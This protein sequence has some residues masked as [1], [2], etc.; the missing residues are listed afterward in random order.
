VSKF[1]PPS[2]FDGYEL[3]RLLGKGGMGAVYLAHDTLLDRPVA[4]K[5][6]SGSSQNSQARERFMVE[7]RAIARLQHT[8]VVS[9]YRVG[10]VAETPYLV[11]EFIRGTPLDRLE[12]P[13][14]SEDALSIALDVASGLA[15]AHRR[16]VVH[17]DI[18]PANAI[19][20]HD[21][22]VK[23]LDFGIAK[24]LPTMQMQSASYAAPALP[25]L[26]ADT[27]SAQSPV[28]PVL[29]PED[30]TA[31][32][33]PDGDPSRIIVDVNECDPYNRTCK[34]K[35]G[36][37]EASAPRAD[38]STM[39]EEEWG[40][41]DELDALTDPGVALGTPRYMA[42]EIWARQ[43]AS[44][45]SDVYSFGALLYSLCAGRPPHPER[46][47]IKLRQNVLT[48]D[49]EPLHQVA[50]QIDPQLCAII[51]RCL[52]RL[53]AERYASGSEL[54]SALVTLLPE[55][56]D[57]KVPAGNPYRGLAAF[58]AQHQNLYFGRD[59]EIR[60]VLER[61][62]REAFVLVAGDSGVGKSSLC[63]AGVLP[64]VDRW[65][66][67]GQK[68]PR[69]WR[70]VSVV[71]GRH[72]VVSLAT[73]LAPYLK[74]DV[75]QLTREIANDQ[76]GVAR[77][78]RAWGG[79][80]RGLV[81]F[82]DQL[83][84]LMTLSVPDEAAATADLLGWLSIAA[85]GLRVLATVRGDFL[86]RAATLPRIGVE[87]PQ[88]LY[89]LRPL[90]AERIRDAITG[91]ADVTKTRFEQAELI[92][93]L[94]SS[95]RQAEAGLP[96]LQFALAEL[97]EARDRER[98]MISRESLDAI[99][100]VIGALNKHADR[101]IRE[102]LPTQ[103]E[104]AREV[105]LALVTSAG[106]RARKSDRELESELAAAGAVRSGR[107]PFGSLVKS[108]IAALVRGRL[109]VAREASDGASYEI[110]HEALIAGWTTL[111]DWLAKDADAKRS[112]E[113]LLLAVDEWR[114]L[115]RASD[116]LWSS[117][118]LQTLIGLDMS[119]LSGDERAFIMTSRRAL[120]RARV[121]RFS[122]IAILVVT[123][124]AAYAGFRLQTK[125]EIS[126]R[127]ASAL[128]AAKQLRR[129]AQRMLAVAK[130]ER[131]TAFA[132]F[133]AGRLKKGEA[134]W[135]RVRRAEDRARGHLRIA[136]T[137]AESAVMLDP[138]R[139][140]SKS[141]VADLLYE[142][143]VLAERMRQKRAVAGLLERLTLYD[144]QGKRRALWQ[145]P[146][147]VTLR[148]Q[149]VSARAT[150]FVNE[151]DKNGRYRKRRVKR[152]VRREVKQGGGGA[153]SLRLAPGSYVFEISAKGHQT[154]HLP[155]LARRAQRLSLSAT[156]LAS[157]RVPRG[158]IHVPAGRMLL[159]SAAEDALRRDFFHHVPMHEVSVPGFLIARYETTYADWIRFLSGLGESERK[160]RLPRV[161]KGGFT[162]RLSLTLDK[163]LAKGGRWRFSMQPTTKR[164]T[165]ASD[166]AV[167]YQK[168]KQRA[169]QRWQRFPVAGI[170]A[171]DA[172]AY[173]RWLRKNGV[174]GA[175]LCTGLE[176][177]RAARGADSRAYP[178]G[179]RLAPDDANHDATYGR[180]SEA[181]GPD[182]VGSHPI[183]QSPFG[184]HDMAGNVW[185]WTRSTLSD[186]R[187]AARGGS[188]YFG[189]N[190]AR[191]TDR[192]ITEP[193]FR[194][195]SVGLR[196]CADLPR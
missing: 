30:S 125:W 191:V 71:P 41:S 170:T 153:Q 38:Q 69:K 81:L 107:A 167:R 2:T 144:Q 12:K 55:A 6:I 63:R 123:L 1:S 98:N 11:S 25:A 186:G 140:K 161:Q 143:A 50:P 44:F 35:R 43:M 90:T 29:G 196:V 60:M 61:L 28:P 112:R 16:G 3:R 129:D 120:R 136:T 166:G 139:P 141:R 48:R 174:V 45:R 76:G 171:D 135:Q 73:A 132:H 179:E 192:E 20:S 82:V 150:L 195:L 184:V 169:S 182:E 36:T 59:S 147:Q 14:S 78:L 42:P 157:D 181:M 49:A 22:V 189:A 46:D 15:A 101:V 193:S 52:E 173:V 155:L 109:L 183:S 58:Q 24:L 83:E 142:R 110:A 100:G 97:W 88:A 149:P 124:G 158:F 163:P 37:G 91:P 108:A 95:A 68:S 7:A 72:P 185:E 18:K 86:S 130:K 117:R 121:M 145:K 168:R 5:F 40:P 10:E 146:A 19:R 99:G 164:Y 175:R 137:R 9:I 102:M 103:R 54:R 84:E 177:E 21:G 89:F 152:R 96:L 122:L 34:P 159:G 17:R 148:V 64:R 156:L 87:V 126:R 4:V 180:V 113:R 118:Q 116:V 188:Y 176:W 128:L 160:K 70:S 105:L 190:S 104:A 31:Q 119:A 67:Q 92:E 47:P 74:K 194:D 79:Q 23:L 172:I 77:Q 39:D 32:L 26:L 154:I 106:T 162:G 65:F 94:V 51:D 131:Q 27:A 56:R 151:L 138:A 111:A 13:V 80:D 134:A 8:N 33:E 133:D 66:A 127:V 165:A 114:R 62:S 53:P 115:D 57:A 93:A 178:H 75:E 187:Y 85:P